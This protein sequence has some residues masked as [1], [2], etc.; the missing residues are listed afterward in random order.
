MLPVDL[1]MPVRGRA[2]RKL[3]EFLQASIA[4]NIAKMV[5]LPRFAL[6]LV[7]SH[8]QSPAQSERSVS[9]TSTLDSVDRP[10]P[11]TQQYAQ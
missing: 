11:P 6:S 2:R 4:S 7:S 5:I 9:T 10:R 1:A 3:Q 8:G